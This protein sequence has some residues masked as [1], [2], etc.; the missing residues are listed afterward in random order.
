MIRIA[1]IG[2]GFSPGRAAGR[3]I[4]QPRV[5]DEHGRECLLDDVTGGRWTVI[6]AAPTAWRD[7]P[8]V[9]VLPA[10]SAPQP[11]AIVDTRGVLTTWMC[12][13]DATV[14]VLRP[15]SVVHAAAK[16]DEPL[17]TPP[18]GA[19]ALNPEVASP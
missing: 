1:V 18:R 12:K 10:G 19:A 11:G 6:G 7:V 3:K 2:T 17:P 16:A 9:R 5:L 14:L 8:A 4:P 13:H 15:D